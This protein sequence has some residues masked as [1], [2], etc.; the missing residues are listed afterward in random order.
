MHRQTVLSAALLAVSLTGCS[1]ADEPSAD[2]EPYAE[3]TEAA[4]IRTG[5]GDANFIV[6]DSATRDGATF[7]FPEVMID[8]PGW[9]VMHPFAD[10]QPVPTVYVGAT[11]LAAGLNTDVQL[12]VT[13]EP[14][15]GEMFVV[16]L[17]YDVNEDGIFDFNDG[18]TVPDR[19]VF[20]G[21]TLVALRYKAP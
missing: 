10:G 20:E 1:N 13:T 16:M 19:P 14:E 9:L 18:I 21:E 15:T 4:Q 7:T 5:N 6:L 11:L 17:H 2:T 12:T 3:P 8:A